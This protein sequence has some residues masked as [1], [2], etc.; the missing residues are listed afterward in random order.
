[1]SSLRPK[2]GGS[3]TAPP[4]PSPRPSS[5]IPI[6]LTVVIIA[7]AAVAY[8]EY[9]TKTALE[10]KIASLEEQVSQIETVQNQDVKKLQASTA[11][12]ASDVPSVSKKI[13]MTADEL[14]Q[15]RQIAEKLRQ[16]QDRQAEAREQLAKELST[17]ASSSDVAAA[18]EEAAKKLADV[19]KAS[20]TKIGTVSN[21]V[22]TVATNLE[23][24]NRDLATSRRE[25][26]DVKTTLADQIAHNSSEI[27][28]LRKKGERE[29]FE[30]ELKKEKKGVMKKVADIQ[31]ALNDTDPKKNK[32]AV[33]IQ[34][35]D[36]KLDKKDLTIN[37][38]VQFLVGRDKLR[39]EIVVNIVDKDKIRGYL[40]APKDKALAA[41]R[42]AYR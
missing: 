23:A 2:E 27:S 9:S 42:P 10:A 35:D 26:V 1:M 3:F 21:D 38:P 18:R 20:D 15:S 4:P 7:I 22:K 39:Y 34:V 6:V 12:L 33:T 13:G 36:N 41:E 16:E 11:S 28:E 30:F 40:S 25:L 32:Y 17:K 31:L 24:T 5:L 37:Q 14:N 8:A 29:Y 19:Q